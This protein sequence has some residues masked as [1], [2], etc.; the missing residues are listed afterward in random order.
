MLTGL[1]VDGQLIRAER[2]ALIDLLESLSPDPWAMPS[3][4]AGWT[5]Q[6]VAAHVAWM[7]APPGGKT[8][9]ELGRSGLRIDR[10]IGDTATRW[11]GEGHL[12]AVAPQRCD[13][14]YPTWCFSRRRT[15]RRSYPPAG[16]P[17]AAG[18]SPASTPKDAFIAVA[19]LQARLRWP[20]S[21]VLAD[22]FSTHSFARSVKC[23]QSAPYG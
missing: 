14:C 6:D 12:G 5:V 16:Y 7:P 18:P 22:S 23:A 9:L 10:M 2:R 17:P 8:V 20:S 21:V 15:R 11:S 4:C 19:E 3:L 1:A 13:K